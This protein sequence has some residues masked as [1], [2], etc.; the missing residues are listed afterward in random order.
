MLRMP[1]ICGHNK[2]ITLCEDTVISRDHIPANTSNS[3][4]ALQV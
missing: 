4:V 1:N 3:Y 2:Y